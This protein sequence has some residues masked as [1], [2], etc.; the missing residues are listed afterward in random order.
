[1]ALEAVDLQV[2]EPWGDQATWLDVN[3][4]LRAA[5]R[6]T[7]A[8]PRD[9]P[10]FYQDPIVAAVDTMDSPTEQRTHRAVLSPRATARSP[11]AAAK[12]A[13]AAAASSPHRSIRIASLALPAASRRAASTFSSEQ[14]VSSR[15]IALARR[16]S[17]SLAMTTSTIRPR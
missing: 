14:P 6:V 11:L 16:R 1:M 17:F 9:H 15:T 12:R 8:D 3:L 7:G 5:G 10:I 13:R 4:V 2:Y